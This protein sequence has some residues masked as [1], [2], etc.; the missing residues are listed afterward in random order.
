MAGER[1][2]ERERVKKTSLIAEKFFFLNVLSPRISAQKCYNIFQYKKDRPG[3][4][5]LL[6]L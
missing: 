5:E 2:R 1:E 6:S 4:K 3:K